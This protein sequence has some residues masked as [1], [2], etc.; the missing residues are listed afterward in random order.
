[1]NANGVLFDFYNTLVSIV[2][3]EY[4]DR[5]WEGLSGFLRYQGISVEPDGLREEFGMSADHG[6][7]TSLEEHPETDVLAIFDR[8][9]SAR[10][11]R[12]V[13]GLSEH[14]VGLF[15]SLSI[16]HFELFPDTVRLLEA[17]HGSFRLGLVTDAQPLFLKPELEMA[18]LGHFFDVI[19]VSGEHGFH[20]PDPRLFQLAL[21]ELELRPQDAIFVGD[22]TRRDICGAQQAHLRAVLVDREHSFNADEALCIPDAVVHTLAELGDL[23]VEQVR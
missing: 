11:S 18:G 6:Q 23:L 20:K 7:R 10:A 2:T 9:L 5:V 14:A 12:S 13:P 19:V 3:D 22:N 1:M 4:D 21:E 8:I 16:R 15:R 17:L